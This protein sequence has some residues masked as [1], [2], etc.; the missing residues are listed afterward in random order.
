MPQEDVR[1]LMRAYAEDQLRR[2]VDDDTVREA[3]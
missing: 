3:A 1:R 2:L